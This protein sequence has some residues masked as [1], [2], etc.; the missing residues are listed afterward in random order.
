MSVTR[1][2]DSLT[3]LGF[4]RR[5][6]ARPRGIAFDIGDLLLIESWA[7]Q[8]DICFAIRLDH[9][10]PAEEYEE[11]IAFHAGMTEVCRAIMWRNARHVFVQPLVGR[12][13]RSDT[14][15]E[16]L[17]SLTPEENVEVTDI[18]AKEWPSDT[19]GG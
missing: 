4:S 9:G 6:V 7:A 16:A 10:A 5:V 3:K 12:R 14:V 15:G 18:V 13:Q 19:V 17:E 11:V 8:Q 1:L 2:P